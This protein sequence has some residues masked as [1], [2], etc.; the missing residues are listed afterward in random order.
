MN[1]YYVEKG[2]MVGLYHVRKIIKE[3]FPK[4]DLC[5]FEDILTNKQGN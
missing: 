3:K 2:Y 1:L 4:E 5:Y